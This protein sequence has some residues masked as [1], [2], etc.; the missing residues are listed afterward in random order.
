MNN[1]SSLSGATFLLALVLAALIG[2]FSL[3]FVGVPSQLKADVL[4]GQRQLREIEQSVNTRRQAITES[5][6]SDPALFQT[7][8]FDP[9]WQARLDEADADL[10]RADAVAAQL[11]GLIQRNK[12]SSV[13]EIGRLLDDEKRLRTEGQDKAASV[14][15]DYDKREN[16]KRDFASTM[17]SI[18]GSA[19]TL[20]AANYS[21]LA[22][23]VEQAEK[24]WPAKREDL[25][26][27]LAALEKRQ[28]DAAEWAATAKQL[29]TKPSEQLTAADYL[30]GGAMLKQADENSGGSA[31]DALLQQTSQL[32]TEWDKV[33]EDLDRESDEY[34]SRIEKVVTKVPSPGA[35]GTVTSS[36][37]WQT[38]SGQQWRGL[39]H[40]IGMTLAHKDFGL[41]DSEANTVPE[42][43]GF[44]YMA[45]PEQGRNQYGY[46]EHRDGGSFWTWLPEYLILRDVLWHHS[47][48][49]VPS[50]DWT[51]YQQAQRT[52][53]TYYGRSET[54]VAKYGSTGTFTQKSYADSRYVQHGGFTASKYANSRAPLEG[55][56]NGAHFG[57][58]PPESNS[59]LGKQFGKSFQRSPGKSFGR[60][61][62]S[63]GRSFGRHR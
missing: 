41:Y 29:A 22:N 18:A 7:P 27:R 50:A 42:P 10:K 19:A 12:H 3:L 33:L 30:T 61:A 58:H 13:G 51:R 26:A 62:R 28:K 21:V 49:P 20:A 14:F 57:G 38:I 45:T 8:A 34:R 23:K 2:L 37:S 44:A 63:A 48:Q 31:A 36:E 11:D 16:F 25:S 35:P 40:N 1:K 54:G 9:A 24:D 47:Y 56:E 5:I 32:Y 43:P 60:I 15:S 17:E 53:T 39:E 4:S 52:G 46:W 6:R 55:R 59:P